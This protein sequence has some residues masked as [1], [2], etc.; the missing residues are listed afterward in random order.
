MSQ[1][2]SRL[3]RKKDSNQNRIYH[4]SVPKDVYRKI[5]EHLPDVQDSILAPVSKEAAIANSP[6]RRECRNVVSGWKNAGAIDAESSP[7]LIR[8]ID[9]TNP[10]RE[11]PGTHIV[12]S[13]G[14]CY[15]H[16]DNPLALENAASN[17]DD[18]MVRLILNNPQP[19]YTSLMANRALYAACTS[20]SDEIVKLLL[21]YDGPERVVPNL[22]ESRALA[23]ACTNGNDKIVKLLLED[24]KPNRVQPSDG[25]SQALVNACLMNHAPIVKRLLEDARPHKVILNETH[26]RALVATE[27]Y[28]R[29]R[30]T[31]LTI[32]KML[33]DH[34]DNNRN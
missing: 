20:N 34:M 7:M 19:Q 24:D 23:I 11:I 13:N 27:D 2:M 25:D 8:C 5:R 1:K 32:I 26:N 6:R 4:P 18:F 31:R 12:G 33:R 28:N 21:D 9:S 17:R 29:G 14:C 3:E 22:E 15:L 10:G 16:I 30:N